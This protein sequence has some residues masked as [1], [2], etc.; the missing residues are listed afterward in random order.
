M[1]LSKYIQ[2]K[3]N[4]IKHYVFRGIEI[5]IKDELPKNISFKSVLEE[6]VAIVP[7]SF[8]KNIDAIYV[9]QFEHLKKRNIQAV[10]MNSS[11]FVTNEQISNDDLLADLVHE[12]A[13]ALEEQ[14]GL[15]IYSDNQ[16]EK[17]FLY[18]R[19]K[20]WNLLKDNGFSIDLKYFLETEYNLEFDE[21]LY[22]TV[23]YP[24]LTTLTVN[25]FFSP[26]AATSLREYF[27]NG[28][29]AFFYDEELSRLSSVSPKLFSKIES[30]LEEEEY[31]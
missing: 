20:L 3:N 27:A 22:S 8:L 17:E 28:F 21:F 19:K 30:L 15:E 9:G 31:Q 7:S 24:L 5:L 14:R 29:E 12:V 23:G 16:I 18:K 13:H 2:N 4:E 25:L 26:Y 11:I 6:L 1:K 10:Y